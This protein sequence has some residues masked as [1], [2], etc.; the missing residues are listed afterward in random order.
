MKETE[1]RRIA[2]QNQQVASLRSPPNSF[3]RIQSLRQSVDKVASRYRGNCAEL[4][5]EL[6]F[7]Q[8]SQKALFGR[9]GIH[10]IIAAQVDRATEGLHVLVAERDHGGLQAGILL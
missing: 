6:R 3:A 8:N 7:C 5:R 4:F 10:F 9:A 2:E 1:T